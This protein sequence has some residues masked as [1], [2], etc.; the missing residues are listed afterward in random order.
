MRLLFYNNEY[1]I[2][3]NKI[4]NRNYFI[5]YANIIVNYD[6]YRVLANVKSDFICKH[7]NV[8]DFECPLTDSRLCTLQLVEMEKIL[9]PLSCSSLCDK[10][11]P[12]YIGNIIDDYYPTNIEKKLEIIKNIMNDIL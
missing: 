6:W 4:T 10:N 8:K 1:T 12:A 11:D 7:I 3:E 2:F 5:V 9:Q